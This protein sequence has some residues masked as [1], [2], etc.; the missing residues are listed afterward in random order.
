VKAAIIS[1][2]HS[3]LVALDAILASIDCDKVDLIISAGDL[4]G[5]GPYP[6]EVISRIKGKDVLGIRG[7]HDLAVLENSVHGMNPMAAEAVRWTTKFLSAESADYLTSLPPRR[8]FDLDEIKA[9]LFHGSPRNDDE[10]VYEADASPDLMEMCGCGLVISGHTHIPYLKRMEQ[11]LMI[12]PGSVG[13]PRDND[14][15]A[16]YALFDT[17]GSRAEIRRVEYD[18][19]K[20]VLAAKEAGLPRFLGERLL[21]GF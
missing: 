11:G 20:V 16:S 7:N 18:V 21:Y 15:R 12:N 2:V 9:G 6:N 4:V 5:Y 10:Y 8:I 17:Q 19:E 1:D 13:Q 14:P 3:N